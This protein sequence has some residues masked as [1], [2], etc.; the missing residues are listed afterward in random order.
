LTAVR[1]LLESKQRELNQSIVKVDKITQGLSELQK[2]Q[3]SS[4]QGEI[5]KLN[6]E[7]GTCHD[8]YYHESSS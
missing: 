4:A 6:R 3:E 2:T 1:D 5:G 7:L 8:S